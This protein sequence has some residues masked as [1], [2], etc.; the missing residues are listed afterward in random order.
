MHIFTQAVM[1]KCFSKWVFLKITRNSQKTP[2]SES[3][4][5]KSGGR[6]YELDKRSGWASKAAPASALARYELYSKGSLRKNP[7]SIYKQHLR[8]P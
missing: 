5:D 2:E 6:E 7:P 3:R 4:L 1:R 8:F